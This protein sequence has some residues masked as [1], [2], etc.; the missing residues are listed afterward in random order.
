MLQ[1]FRFAFRS[2][3]KSPGFT[4]IAVLCLALSIGGNTA[5]FSLINGLFLKP[6]PF[7]HPE[8]LVDIDE[9]A[10]Q[11]NLR[12]AGIN[13]GDFEAWRT[14]NQ[15]FAGMAHFRSSERSVSINGRSERLPVQ[16]VTHDL[17]DVFGFQPVLGRMFRADEEMGDGARVALIG[18]H[19]WQDWFAGSR[20]V[21]GQT[22]TIDAE[23]YEI[24]GVL[25]PTAVM[26]AR[27][28]VWRPFNA[29]PAS[30]NWAGLVVG[31]LKPGVT[32]AQANA[33]LLRIHRARIPEQKENEIT[34]P[35]VQPLLDRHLGGVGAIAFVLQSAVVVLLLVAAANVAGLVLARTLHRVP[36]LGLRAALGASRAQLVRQLM[37]ESG[38]LSLLGAA[39]GV[40]IGRWLLDAIL[41]LFPDLPAWLRLDL[42]WRFAV[43]VCG[44]AALCT[45]FAGL[46]PARHVLHRLDMG[47]VVGASPHQITSSRER[48]LPLR[49][50]VIAEIALALTLLLVAALFGRA[51]LRVRLIDTGLRAER[52]LTY[53]VPLP[54][55]KYRTDAARLA[56]FEEH[57]ARLR[58]LPEVEAASAST[59]LP[60]S[61]EHMGNFFV[62]EGAPPPAPDTRSPVVLTRASFPGYFETIG[63]AIVA[64]RSFT[65]Q[66][67]RD[68][69]IVNETLARHF[70][71]EE[72]AVG[73]RLR[74]R[75]SKGP[76][77]EVIGVAH[78]VK[79]YGI[80]R[81]TPL[82]IYVPFYA[83]PRTSVSFVVRTRGDPAALA[84]TLRALLR[85]Q[86][87]TLPLAGLATLEQRIRESTFLRRLYSGLT[88]VFAG[89]AVAI[90]MTGI[91]GI[92]AYVVG[93]RTR[94]F[95]IR[96]AL[97]ARTRD[98]VQL[99]VQEGV[100]L[101]AIG[102]AL[103][104][105]GGGL[106]GLALRGLL[107]GV[108]PFDPL[109]LSGTLAVLAA[110]V[111]AA[112][113]MPA[114]RTTRL[115]VVDV[116]RAE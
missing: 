97:G 35:I 4:A 68:V 94:E 77:L 44:A 82:G 49:L 26:P 19:I 54:E 63:I 96:L 95:G 98:L 112:C 37:I 83:L 73:K 87:A 13:Y 41:G 81:D 8:Q 17:A 28:A 89:V 52:V 47:G 42:D 43:F 30:D 99:V 38:V 85:H 71:P 24:I 32:V 100:Q 3:G 6:L 57:L 20:D 104:L 110:V 48:L 33:D 101:G 22:L 102:L 18:H 50:L 80:E 115:D 12:Y 70:W 10:P 116:L 25:P 51:L 67:R 103:G 56:F 93:Q 84:P 109:V 64:G 78:D 106:A 69:V 23:V 40:L 114:R 36:E 90:A 105:V 16:R 72:N 29:R 46:I 59:V 107:A 5:V 14:Q 86:D 91:Y 15:T 113:L 1:D 58:A 108:Q 21:I 66:D 31:R 88:A 39:A 53:T 65:E 62:A 61:G 74:T 76:W 92:V 75:G 55:A 111:L 60:F 45:A 27:A 9:T 7:P 2:L 79:H 11:W 34:S